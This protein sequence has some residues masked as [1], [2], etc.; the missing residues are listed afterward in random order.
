[1]WQSRYPLLFDKISEVYRSDAN[2]GPDKALWRHDHDDFKPSFSA[3]KTLNYLCIKKTD[4]PW[5]RLVWFPQA[6]PRQSFMV[7]L[8]FKDRL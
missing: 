5:H 2:A 7:W 4:I 6:F 8:A 1:M 3:S